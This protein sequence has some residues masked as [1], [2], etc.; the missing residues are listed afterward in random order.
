MLLRARDDRHVRVGVVGWWLK[1]FDDFLN[2][3]FLQTKK[4]LYKDE[5]L[6]FLTFIN[7]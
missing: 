6:H 4:N 5:I 2:S 3:N 1:H 7:M